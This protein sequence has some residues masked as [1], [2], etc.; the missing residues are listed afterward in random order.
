[1]QFKE[2]QELSIQDNFIFQKV[3]LKKSIC[4]AVL[5]R[6]LDI[7][8]KDI[9]YIQEEKTLDV[10]LETK[11]VRLDVYVNDDKGTVYNIEMQTYKNMPE[12][13]KR[14]RFYHSAI[15][16][17][18]ME[19]GADYMTLNDCFVIFIC[20]FP[21]FSGKRHKYTYTKKCTEE[22]GREL[23]D[24]LT[25]IFLSTK[26]EM[27]DVSELLQNFLDYVDGRPPSDGLL[28]QM[29]E[30]VHVVK[31]CKEWRGEY[32]KLE[33]DR[34]KYWREGKEAGKVEGT[35][36]AIVGMLREKLS[37]EMIARITNM[38]VD[39]VIQIG[40]EHALL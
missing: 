22:L 5:E 39:Q 16:H 12:L 35:L 25:T 14:S 8:I 21:I 6:L 15:D 7:S 9:V 31:Q 19:K 34:K 26:A 17:Y 29:D 1:M 27:N 24:G 3:M 37:V 38:P 11:S 18:S 4:K 32:M 36:E 2:F 30:V 23:G 33:M 10:S 20:T 28:Q 13:I 40:K